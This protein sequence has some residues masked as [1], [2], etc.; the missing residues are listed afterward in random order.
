[1]VALEEG[2][3]GHKLLQ[4]LAP[5]VP[6]L[7]G[8]TTYSLTKQLATRKMLEILPVEFAHAN[9]ECDMRV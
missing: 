7:Y 4:F 3:G 9:G 2:G 6:G 1:M 8:S 5:V